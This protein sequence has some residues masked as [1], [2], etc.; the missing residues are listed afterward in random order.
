[1]QT[2]MLPFSPRFIILTLCILFS[3]LLTAAAIYDP[4]DII[5]FAIPFV[6]FVLL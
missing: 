4:D 2:L 5:L 3:I 1:M 6:V